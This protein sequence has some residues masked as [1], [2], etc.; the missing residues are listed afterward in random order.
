[1]GCDNTIG[2]TQGQYMA[3]TTGIKSHAYKCK[4][5][6]FGAKGDKNSKVQNYTRL[7]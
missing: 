7:T 5:S 4:E 2:A 1:M 3:T 6:M